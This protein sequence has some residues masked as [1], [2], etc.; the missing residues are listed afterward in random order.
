[1]KLVFFYASVETLADSVLVPNQSN[2]RRHKTNRLNTFLHRL[3]Q[4]QRYR[5]ID[6]FGSVLSTL[7]SVSFPIDT[8]NK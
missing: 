3:I 1:M 4:S 8:A 6:P 2:A 5:C 7:E